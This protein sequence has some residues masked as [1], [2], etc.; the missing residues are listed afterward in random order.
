M[1][2]AQFNNFLADRW[3]PVILFACP[4]L[5]ARQ[6]GGPGGPARNLPGLG[7]EAALHCG[8]LPHYLSGNEFLSVPDCLL[9]TTYNAR[10]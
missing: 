9:S 2:L 4:G 1:C 7:T 8:P 3:H 6:Q 10:M 5:P